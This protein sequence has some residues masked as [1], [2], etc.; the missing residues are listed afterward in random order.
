MKRF[1]CMACAVVLLATGC[2][3]SKESGAGTE[4]TTAAAAQTGTTAAAGEQKATEAK[5]DSGDKLV[6]WF[7]TS[8]SRGDHGTCDV[9][10]NAL[11]ELQEK[12]P[13]QLDIHILEAGKDQS[14]YEAQFLEV[15]D[16]GCDIFTCSANYSMADLVS[17]YVNDYPETVFWFTDMG[18]EYQFANPDT[19]SGM[20]FK[21]NEVMFLSGAL[22]AKLSKTGVI[23]FVGGMEST[24]ICDFGAGYIDGARYVNPDIKVIF[25][26]VGNFDDS[27]KGKELALVQANMGADVIHNVAGTAGLGVLEACADAGIYALGVDTDQRETFL[28]KGDQKIADAIVTSSLKKWGNSHA[29]FVERYMNDPD[30]INWGTIERWGIKEDG[31]GLCKNDYYESNV[32][33]DLKSFIEELETKVSSGEITPITAMGME[34][35]EWEE[36]KKSVAL[37]N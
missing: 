1:L 16:S 19:C 12:Y 18:T 30:S 6:V 32:P 22:A 14:L 8:G 13:D 15:L 36:L 9:T 26:F 33:D 35:S 20:A 4:T 3:S 23:G 27:A 21:Q 25:S 29:L 37:D 10:W 11:A 31:V 7:A 24:V 17:K 34:T 2:S 5:T 28:N